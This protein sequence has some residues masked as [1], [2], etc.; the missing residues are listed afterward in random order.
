ML[1]WRHGCQCS[2][3][4]SFI[5]TVIVSCYALILYSKVLRPQLSVYT[6]LRSENLAVSITEFLAAERYVVTHC[7]SEQTF[8]E[9]LALNKQHIDCLILEAYP[10]LVDL[11]NRLHQQATLFPAAIVYGEAK[12]ISDRTGSAEEGYQEEGLVP[13]RLEGEGSQK[14]N[15]LYGGVLYH[16]AEVRMYASQLGEITRYVEE[17]IA[18]FL[19]L[20]PTPRGKDASAPPNGTSDPHPQEFLQFQQRRLAEKLRERLGYLGVYYKR[21][22][23]RFVRNLPAEE[24]TQFIEQLKSGYRDILLNYFENAS[25]QNKVIDEFVNFAF[26]ADVSVTQIVEIHMQLMEEFS[27]HL[28]MEGRSAEVLTDYRLTLIDVIAHLCEMYRRSIPRDA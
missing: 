25:N 2:S 18:Q 13:G 9:V 17:A 8:L 11:A 27:K 4:E 24:R 28:K 3:P 22:T 1:R 7:Q 5:G 16:E 20:S 10:N 15:P 14:D 23:Q 12:K 19:N 26:F 6:L 21:N